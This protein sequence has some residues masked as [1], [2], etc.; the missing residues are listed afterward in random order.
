ML[1]PLAKTIW[2]ADSY[3]LGDPMQPSVNLVESS[4]R[5]PYNNDHVGEVTARISG[6]REEMT[7]RI[8]GTVRIKLPQLIK[9][10]QMLAIASVRRAAVLHGAKTRMGGDS[11]VTRVSLGRVGRV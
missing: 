3:A 6:T 9:I 1:T 10:G 7:S 11:G 4:R 8:I 2:I 5:Y